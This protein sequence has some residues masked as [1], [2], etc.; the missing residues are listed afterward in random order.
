[1]KKILLTTAL[2]CPLAA[3]AQDIKPFDA[4]LGLWESTS[5]A[6]ISGMPAMPA[7]P[8]I[9]Q[10]TLDRMPP[11]QRAQVEAMM[12]G[13]GAGS[14]RTSTSKFCIDQDSLRKAFYSSD[15]SCT[16]KLVSAT[17][18]TQ[19]IHVE[20]NG[21][22]KGAGDLTLERVDAEHMKGAMVMKMTGDA[23]GGGAGR[24]MD[25]KVTFSNKWLSADCGD[26][27]PVGE[28]NEK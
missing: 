6:E 22:A 5:S 10:E 13:R 23:R 18:S 1:V 7:M 25:M 4:K 11:A 3:W 20:C 15:K 19:Q 16:T 14:P 8:A 24:S 17:A 9:P 2:L 12:K 21:A 28:I 27:K 26:V